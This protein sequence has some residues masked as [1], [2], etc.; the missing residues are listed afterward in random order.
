M[1]KTTIPV[2]ELGEMDEELLL[3]SLWSSGTESISFSIF[4]TI[5]WLDILDTTF[6]SVE[7][8]FELYAEELMTDEV[9][10]LAVD[11]LVELSWAGI[12]D[13]AAVRLGSVLM[14][15]YCLGCCWIM[16]WWSASGTCGS[17]IGWWITIWLSN[18]KGIIL[19][20]YYT[21]HQI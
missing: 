13:A 18:Q 8:D 2:M 19:T 10:G 6:F 7:D 11:L 17:A 1:N 21:S 14:W 3:L 20:I 15:I 4:V 5:V 12:L 16:V 9:I